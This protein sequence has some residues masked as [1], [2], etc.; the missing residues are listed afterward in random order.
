M[1]LAEHHGQLGVAA[2]A[3]HD[4]AGEGDRDGREGGDDD[5]AP[6]FGGVGG[7]IGLGGVDRVEDRAGVLHETASRV[8]QLRRSGGAFQQGDTGLLLQS[9]QLLRDGRGGLAGR[10]GSGDYRSV[11]GEFVEEAQAADIQHK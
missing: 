11:G 9:G 4:R 1:L 6:R 10:Q 3:P 5:P 2:Q 8:G 7:Q